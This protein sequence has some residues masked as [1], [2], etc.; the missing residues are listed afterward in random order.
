MPFIYTVF[1]KLLLAGLI[2][3]FIGV[4]CF[5]ANKTAAEFAVHATDVL[6]GTLAG[7]ITG[8]LLKSSQQTTTT[9]STTSG[10]PKDAAS[11]EKAE[12]L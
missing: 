11:K 9:T 4:M 2:L 7:L 8:A 1:D 5:T 6:I 10:S 3:V 12:T